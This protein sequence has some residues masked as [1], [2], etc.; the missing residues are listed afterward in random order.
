MKTSRKSVI[1]FKDISGDW[2]DEKR[3]NEKEKSSLRI[4]F[5]KSK[6]SKLKCTQQKL[7]SNIQETVK[8]NEP[9]LYIRGLKHFKKIKVQLVNI[10]EKKKE[11]LL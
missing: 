7:D 11:I 5:A 6:S 4:H 3:V 10:G 1:T 9:R 8:C 2:N